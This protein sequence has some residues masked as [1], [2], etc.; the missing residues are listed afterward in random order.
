MKIYTRKGDKGDTG[1]LAGARVRKDH[2]RIEAY[3]TVDELNALL[4][5]ARSSSLPPEI[6]A[7]ITRVQSELFEVGAELATSGSPP[8]DRQRIDG[9]DV[10]R[11]ESDVDRFDR[12]L[13][14]LRQFILPS[15]TGGAAALHVARAVCRRAE[16]R[17]VSLADLPGECVSGH[18]VAYLNRLSDLLFVLARSANATE[19]QGDAPWAK[20]EK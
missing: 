16:R 4:G 18:V 11:L 17:A 2:P 19:G 6:D 15:G 14:A 3:G 9:N 1:L 12:Q 8:R 10:T 5:V 20:R 13:P 7:V